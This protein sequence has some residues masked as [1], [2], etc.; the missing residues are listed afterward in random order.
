MVSPLTNVYIR[1]VLIGQKSEQS[2]EQARA[3]AE[4]PGSEIRQ[5]QQ[6]Q[7]QQG[8][9]QQHKKGKKGGRGGGETNPTVVPP[10]VLS[11]TLLPPEDAARALGLQPFTITLG[12]DVWLPDSLLEEAA[13]ALPELGEAPPSC[14]PGER[15]A[16]RSRC[17][18]PPSDTGRFQGDGSTASTEG[19]ALPEVVASPGSS[20]SLTSLSGGIAL[21]AS[22]A[23]QRHTGHDRG[24]GGSSDGDMGRRLLIIVLR[25]LRRVLGYEVALDGMVVLVGSF[26]GELV[27]RPRDDRA[28][29]DVVGGHAAVQN[30]EDQGRESWIMRCRWNS[31][32]EH[33]ANACL[34]ALSPS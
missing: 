13:G 7:Q 18:V 5:E 33:V 28:A 3:S 30:P 16:K 26:E 25:Y 2:S 31:R 14:T 19:S 27:R 4:P 29:A 12:C 20:V 8:Q 9:Q 21:P 34:K 24:T 23:L 15:D 22:L 10:P 17:D 11:A 32:D 6:Q 1:G